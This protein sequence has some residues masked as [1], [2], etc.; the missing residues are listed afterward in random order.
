MSG[1]DWFR[2]FKHKR[3]V[4][5]AMTELDTRHATSEPH[6]LDGKLIV[7]L[8]SYVSRFDMLAHTLRSLLKQSMQADQ[9]ILWVG[10]SDYDQLP[11]DV[12]A[13]Q[14][15]G[16]TIK[17]TE[18][19]RSYTKIIPTLKTHPDAYIVTADD[20]VYYEAN[21]LSDLVEAHHKSGAKVICHRA[22]KVGLDPH[23]MPKPYEEWTQNYSE[24]EH[25]R[26]VFPTGV[27]GV[28]YAPNCFDDRVVD[29][30]LFQTLCP[31]ADDVWLYWMHR[32]TGGCAQKI[33]GRRR[34]LEW[35][36]QP[37]S[38]LRSY[39]VL[40]NG[41]DTQIKALIEKFGFPD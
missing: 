4:A 29:Q 27:S 17:A 1:S 7:S 25:S 2:R 8:T 35:N 28:F 12:L 11:D 22:H 37:S 41:N 9:T 21:W 6:G 32:L 20:D 23:N 14:A 34:I 26:V 5:R 15:M 39:N 33:G 30:S 24:A 38:D 13:C 36:M 10:H 18:D 16:L 19:I 3:R 31:H 40:E